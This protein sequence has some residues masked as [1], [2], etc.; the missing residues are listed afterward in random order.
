MNDDVLAV[1]AELSWLRLSIADIEPALLGKKEHIVDPPDSPENEQG[2]GVGRSPIL[3][4]R[5]VA[6]EPLSALAWW[7]NASGIVR[8]SF[9]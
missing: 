2:V 8:L 9:D 7:L 6:Y 3:A 1:R 4:T 5:A